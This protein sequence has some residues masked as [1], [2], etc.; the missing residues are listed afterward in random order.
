MRNVVKEKKID[1]IRFLKDRR[2]AAVT[3]LG[4]EL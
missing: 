3:L 1:L 2:L 4:I